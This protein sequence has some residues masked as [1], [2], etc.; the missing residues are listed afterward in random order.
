[1]GRPYEFVNVTKMQYYMYS[2]SALYKDGI[3][4][5]LSLF[6]NK[7]W[8]ITDVIVHGHHLLQDWDDDEIMNDAT[9]DKNVYTL[10]Y[11]KNPIA[12]AFPDEP[13]KDVVFWKTQLHQLLT[14]EN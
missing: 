13:S 6:Q 2:S 1:M 7:I 3:T 9:I 8:D 14:E 10:F 11:N 4:K 5:L 12:S